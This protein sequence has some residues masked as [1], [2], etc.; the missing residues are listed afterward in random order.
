MTRSPFISLLAPWYI[1][2]SLAEI[3]LLAKHLVGERLGVLL[4]IPERPVLLTNLQKP[5]AA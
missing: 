4:Y 1:L 2:F 5:L 3:G